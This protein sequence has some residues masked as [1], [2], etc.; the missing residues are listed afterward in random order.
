[1]SLTKAERRARTKV[2]A[3]VYRTQIKL[4]DL[5]IDLNVERARD[6]VFR[7]FMSVRE[8]LFRKSVALTDGDPLP[9]D[10]VLA[11]NRAVVT[12]TGKK[13]AY[14]NVSDVGFVT[15]NTWG[16]ATSSTACYYFSDQ[17]FV[18]VPAGLACTVY[19]YYQPVRLAGSGINDT[20]QDNM[21]Q[22][23]EA[24]IIAGAFERCLQ[25]MLEEADAL[26]LTQV[27]M[28]NTQ[29]SLAQ[30][31]KNYFDVQTEEARSA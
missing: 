13:M 26:K 5:E 7:R 3:M 31:Y 16:T 20:T 8:S 17:K 10:W 25:M 30:F 9:N 19:Y 29:D 6:E 11:A 24:A 14:I 21:P 23:L 4:E 12:G 27:E 2:L 28:E 1:M 18:T 15:K 22:E